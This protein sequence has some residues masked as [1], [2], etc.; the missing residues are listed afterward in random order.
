MTQAV[1]E[2]LVMSEM[3]E[4]ELLRAQFYGLLA[5]ALAAPP[6]RTLLAATARLTG[7]ETEFGRAIASLAHAADAATVEDAAREYHD[8]FIGLVRGELVPF[9]SFYLTGFLH[10]RPLAELRQTLGALGIGRAE[11]VK[12]PEDHIAALLEVMAGLIAGAYGAPQP[13]AVQRRFFETHLAPW[14]S[15]FFGDLEQAKSAALYALVGRLGRIFM[16]IEAE[17]FSMADA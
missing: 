14:A 5:G 7:D 2:T 3:P 8:L 9:A 4:E 1:A 12:E 16:A 13:L 15:R 10:E 6:D 17:A 11:G